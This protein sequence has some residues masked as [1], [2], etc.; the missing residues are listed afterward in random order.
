MYQAHLSYLF[1]K[2]CSLTMLVTNTIRDA[3]ILMSLLILKMD[4]N[5]LVKVI[6]SWLLLL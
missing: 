5:T 2:V 4:L 1:S 6:K 3:H